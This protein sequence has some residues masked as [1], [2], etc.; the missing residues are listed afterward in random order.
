MENGTM[1]TRYIVDAPA[2]PELHGLEFDMETMGKKS[3]H[4]VTLNIRAWSIDS[5]V[6]GEVRR[7]TA[8]TAAPPP[9]PKS[10]RAKRGGE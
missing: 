10:A 4:C 3:L 1:R 2:Y 9:M 6:G 5:E 7:Q 8:K